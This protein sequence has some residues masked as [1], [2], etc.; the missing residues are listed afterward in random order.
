VARGGKRVV[1]VVAAF[2]IAAG[3]GGVGATWV[4][5]D[6]AMLRDTEADHFFAAERWTIAHLPHDSR[7]VVED[8]FWTDLVRAGWDPEKVIWHEKIDGD[9]DV[10]RRIPGGWRG[11]DYVIASSGL[12]SR[13]KAGVM[14]TLAKALQHSKVVASFGGGDGVIEIRHI[15]P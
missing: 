1:A 5:A 14:P 13:V 4:N 11:V 8:V 15:E 12:R 9:P 2:A 7:I 6:A 3:V 10:H